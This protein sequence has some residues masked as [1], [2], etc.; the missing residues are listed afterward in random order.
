MVGQA[1]IVPSEHHAGGASY[2]RSVVRIRQ[3]GQELVR[4][5]DVVFVAQI[6]LQ[7][8]EASYEFRN[9]VGIE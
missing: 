2:G 5:P 8:L 7:R 4:H 9:L 3:I 6:I 1:P